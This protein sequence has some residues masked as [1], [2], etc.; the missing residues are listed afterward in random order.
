MDGSLTHLYSPL[1]SPHRLMYVSQWGLFLGIGF[2][3]A[4]PGSEYGDSLLSTLFRIAPIGIGSVGVFFSN[5]PCCLPARA[6]LFGQRVMSHIVRFDHLTKSIRFRRLRLT[7]CNLMFFPYICMCGTIPAY[8]SGCRVHI[9]LSCSTLYGPCPHQP[10]VPGSM[11][12]FFYFENINC[13]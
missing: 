3:L 8:A 11:G 12:A 10:S 9:S 6:W 13:I 2:A 4:N 5:P 1:G 7:Y